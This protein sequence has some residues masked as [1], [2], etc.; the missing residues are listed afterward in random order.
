M[1]LVGVRDHD[2]EQ[3]VVRLPKPRDIGQQLFLSFVRRVERQA[4]VERDALTLGL[5]LDAGAAD[6]LG[7]PVDT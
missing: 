5:D 4:D 7:A 3:A 2:A 6:L 1:I